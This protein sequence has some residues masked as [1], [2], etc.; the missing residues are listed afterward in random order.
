MAE[1]GNS[2]ATEWIHTGTPRPGARMN[3]VCLPHAGGSPSFYREWGARLPGD[4]EVHVVRYPG[5]ENRLAEPCILAMTE[6]ADAVTEVIRPF[7]A[8]PT[9]LFGHSMGASLMYEVTKRSEAA[10]RHP[11]LL[12]A[13]GHPAP[14]RRVPKKL[15]QSS[16][17]ELVADLRRHSGTGHAALDDPDLR[18]LLLP[19]IRA[20][21]RLIETYEAGELAPVRAPLAVF[22]GAGDEDVSEA[23]AEAW[24]EVTKKG[25]LHAHRVFDGRHFYLA[26]H[27]EDVLAAVAAEISSVHQ[28]Y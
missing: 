27:Q 2:P 22:R 20:D 9:V 26:E 11:V 13:S 19:M 28:S 6:L 8:R 7:F 15:Y 17:Q 24:V 4:V 12:I 23:Q 10:G 1:K 18:E 16:D 3:L 5:R 25:E 14:H 21:Y